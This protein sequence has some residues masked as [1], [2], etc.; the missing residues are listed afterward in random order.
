V[1]AA[2]AVLQAWDQDF[3]TRLLAAGRPG[4]NVGVAAAPYLKLASVLAGLSELLQRL[5]GLSL[6]EQKVVASE[7]WAPGMMWQRQ[8]VV[9]I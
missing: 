6:Q 9:P 5:M 4:C 7:A 2:G 1:G 3:Y 8:G